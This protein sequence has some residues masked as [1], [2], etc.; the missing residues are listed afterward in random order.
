MDGYLAI[1][2][3][4][5]AHEGAVLLGRLGGMYVMTT[6]DRRGNLNRPG[7]HNAESLTHPGVQ[8]RVMFRKSRSLRLT[9]N[10]ERNGV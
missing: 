3:E 4:H 5:L 2:A 7:A 1:V 8:H 9:I 10:Q 6:K